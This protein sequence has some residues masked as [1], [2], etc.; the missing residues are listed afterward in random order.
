MKE[1]HLYLEILANHRSF[2]F[3]EWLDLIY[4]A[5]I[6]ESLQKG[7]IYSILVSFNCELLIWNN[8]FLVVEIIL[9]FITKF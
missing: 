9:E 5:N 1:V 8:C 2:K 6:L 7:S 3:T 4:I